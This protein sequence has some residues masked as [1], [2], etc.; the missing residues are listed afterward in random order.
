MSKLKFNFLEL[1]TKRRFLEMVVDEQSWSQISCDWAP[2][3]LKGLERDCQSAKDALK[4]IKTEEEDLRSAMD[5]TCQQL[6]Q[7]LEAG[8][9]KR[10]EALLLVHRVRQLLS[11]LS[12]RQSS[13]HGLDPSCYSLP[14]LNAKKDR[15]QAEVEK[16][17][18]ALAVQRQAVSDLTRLL[19]HQSDQLSRSQSAHSSLQQD[20]HKMSSSPNTTGAVSELCRWYRNIVELVD[21]LT[22]VHCDIVRSDYLHVTVTNPATAASVP[23]HLHVDPSTGRLLSCS[24]GSTT[25]TPRMHAQWRDLVDFAIKHNDI[26]LLIRQVHYKLVR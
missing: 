2:G 24:I 25:S 17:K 8:H 7:K 6:A 9:K 22:G 16:K 12:A 4:E 20:L 13:D 21:E 11:D 26:P 1:Q 5:V 3:P 23:I 15:L 18:A 10:Q 19:H 14:E